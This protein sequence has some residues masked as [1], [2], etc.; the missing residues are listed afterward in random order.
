MEEHPKS[1]TDAC[2]QATFRIVFNDSSSS[3]VLGINDVIDKSVMLEPFDLPGMLLVQQGKDSSLAVTNSAADDGSSIFHVVLGL[4]G[5]DGTVSLES[6]SQE[7]C[8]IYSGVNY[9]SGQ[10]MKLSCKLGST[11]Y[12]ATLL[13][14]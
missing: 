7:G 6:G 10:S 8:Y 13:A 4:D 3:E 2:L 12:I 14:S 1:G 5:K 9:K 11:V